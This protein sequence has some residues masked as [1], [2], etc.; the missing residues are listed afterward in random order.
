M[1]RGLA[2]RA[3][4]GA[5]GASGGGIALP[6][7]ATA[8]Y[9]GMG[10]EAPSTGAQYVGAYRMSAT[11]TIDAQYRFAT[12][13]DSSTR[14]VKWARGAPWIA[15][16]VA[17]AT[18]VATRTH[19]GAAFGATASTA[20]LP[21]AGTGG[22]ASSLAVAPANDRIVAF[23]GS[24]FGAL[25]TVDPATGV[26]TGT[27]ASGF[28]SAEAAAQVGEVAWSPAGDAFGVCQSSAPNLRFYT[29]AGTTVT[30]RAVTGW[31]PATL[32][33]ARFLAWS[34]D[35]ATCFV[36][37]SNGKV[38][39]AVTRSGTAFTVNTTPVLNLGYFV[40]SLAVSP[41]GTMLLIGHS[42]GTGFCTVSGAT[43][44]A[45]TGLGAGNSNAGVGW[46][47]D[48]KR[49]YC[50]WTYTALDQVYI[51]SWARSGNTFGTLTEAVLSTSAAS[52]LRPINV[53]LTIAA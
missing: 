52:T 35:G 1:P 49:A 6:P 32:G 10:L 18:T 2:G 5:A 33:T 4:R 11:G 41:D 43:L 23:A 36:A 38:L 25:Y 21:S 34:A 46:S 7:S 22:A 47:P 50:V 16:Q 40:L 31:D 28:G 20:V 45:V 37:T 17:N 15:Y 12:G 42:N 14:G 24:G 44:G 9:L 27:V 30:A 3:L 48:G 13:S 29:I 8:T 51:D 39:Y 26:F 19:T 53:T